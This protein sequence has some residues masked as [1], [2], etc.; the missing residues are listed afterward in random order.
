[1]SNTSKRIAGIRAINRSLRAKG[2][3]AKEAYA[4]APK[5]YDAKHAE[6]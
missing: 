2:Y 6:N 1:M 4:I 5:I 3:T